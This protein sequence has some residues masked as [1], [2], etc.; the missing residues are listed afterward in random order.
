MLNWRKERRML[1]QV[2]HDIKRRLLRA[3]RLIRDRIRSLQ[4]DKDRGLLV[5][6]RLLSRK[7]AVRWALIGVCLG[8]GMG[9]LGMDYK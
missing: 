1:K 8:S 5:G 3:E 7:H 6:K 9:V 2:Q 4:D